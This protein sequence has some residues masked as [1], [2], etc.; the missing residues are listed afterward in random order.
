M[1]IN[2]ELLPYSSMRYPTAGDYWKDKSGT[3][4]FRIANFHNPHYECLVLVHELIECFL[5]DFAGIREEDITA[6]DVRFEQ[7]REMGLH[8]P[9]DEPGHDP[10]SPYRKYHVFAEKVERMVAKVLRV[11]WGFYSKACNDLGTK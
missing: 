1:K 6:F 3:W 10:K 8:G 2:V 4:Q 11:R 9:D 7:E 5:C